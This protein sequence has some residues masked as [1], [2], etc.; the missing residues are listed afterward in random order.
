[1]MEVLDEVLCN[2]SIKL[3][4]QTVMKKETTR[5]Y[6]DLPDDLKADLYLNEDVPLDI[7]TL[8]A[9]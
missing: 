2:E 5:S 9:D 1:M 4:V 3:I 8:F 6:Q 7:A